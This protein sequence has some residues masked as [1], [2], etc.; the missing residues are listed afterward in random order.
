MF[1][2]EWIMHQKR[3]GNMIS[4]AQIARDLGYCGATIINLK[5]GRMRPTPR[6]AKAVEDYTKGKVTVEDFKNQY[7]KG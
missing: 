4:C 7:P 6:L 2:D 1:L 3:S 5:N